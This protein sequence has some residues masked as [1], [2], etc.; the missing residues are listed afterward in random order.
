[1]RF[2]KSIWLLAAGFIVCAGLIGPA[3][4]QVVVSEEEQLSLATICINEADFTVHR[5]GDC[6][7]IYEALRNFARQRSVGARRA[8]LRLDVDDPDEAAERAQLL[9]D[10]GVGTCE[11]IE[12]TWLEHARGVEVYDPREP[13]R[14][15]TVVSGHSDR[16]F[17]RTRTD[18][19][20]YIA[21]L[22]ADGAE[23]LFWPT[24]ATRRETCEGGHWPHSTSPC[25]DGEVSVRT[26]AHV[27]WDRRRPDFEASYA[28]SGSIL[29]GEVEAECDAPPLTWGCPGEGRR[30]CGDHERAMERGMVRVDCGEDLSNWM[31]GRADA[32][33][34]G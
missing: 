1:M 23:P 10:H 18:A 27:G 8:C 17:D 9:A 13:D 4:A 33:P 30:D 7:A 14:S 16:A 22:R 25:T 28:L 3:G 12:I 24:S 11:E 20:R 34:E 31:Y 5:R 19:R 32:A 21:F 15:R 6:P 26:V 2:F 29:R